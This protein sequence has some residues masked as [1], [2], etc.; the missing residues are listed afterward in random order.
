MRKKY[1]RGFPH[2]WRTR[3]LLRARGKPGT[4]SGTDGTSSLTLGASTPRVLAVTSPAFPQ[5]VQINSAIAPDYKLQRVV[6][7]PSGRHGRTFS[8]RQACNT[9]EASRALGVL[10]GELGSGCAIQRSAAKEETGIRDGCC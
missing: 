8:V 3:F 4:N 7:R 1:L 2:P 9:A 5:L 10:D 6:T